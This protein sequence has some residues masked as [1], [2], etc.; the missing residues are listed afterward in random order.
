MPHSDIKLGL[1]LIGIGR[2]WGHADIEVPEEALVFEFLKGAYDL[3]VD[4]FD[5]AASYG[6][7]E[8]RLG[9]F[10]RTLS[11]EQR[12]RITVA[13]K[14]GDHWDDKARDSYVDHSF[15]AL[16]ASLDRSLSRLSKIDIL[17][18]HKTTP[19]A[20]KS[21][22]LKR[23][24]D[25]AGGKGISRFGASVS[26]LESGRLVCES[27]VFSIIQCPYNM[28]NTKFGEII[29]LAEEKHKLVL[30]NRPFGMGKFLYN[31]V[32]E[33]ADKKARQIEAYA[34]ILRKNFHGFILSGTKS[35]GHLRENIE[36]FRIASQGAGR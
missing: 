28:E 18:L 24:L 16:R 4:F 34:F 17:Q 10:L 36:A 19:Q 21:D 13:T 5:C 1:G 14:F 12:D 26:D 3:N 25:Y 6:S 29:D 9:I 11:R 33:V 23:A 22:D 30:T 35:L 27:G 32:Q 15:E 2:Q 8:E 20:L 7:S 31:E